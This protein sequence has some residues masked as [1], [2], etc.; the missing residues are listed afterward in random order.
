MENKEM[1]FDAVYRISVAMDNIVLLDKV[2]E[3]EKELA[4]L[5][6]TH[7]ELKGIDLYLKNNIPMEEYME[8]MSNESISNY[9][10]ALADVKNIMVSQMAQGYMEMGEINLQI[11]NENAQIID[12][13]GYDVSE[14][15]EKNAKTGS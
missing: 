11:A 12:N 15:D 3:L 1:V 5:G 7:E 13:E 10:D 6:Y 4:N 2:E 8:Y 14:V 9:T